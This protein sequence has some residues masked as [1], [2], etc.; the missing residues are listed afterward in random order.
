MTLTPQK[1]LNY[2]EAARYLS[3]SAQTLRRAVDAGRLRA[4]RPGGS[5]C[6]RFAVA[7]LDAFATGS[8]PEGD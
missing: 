7:D 2:N 3:L 4:L 8:A 6:V 5:R 1:F